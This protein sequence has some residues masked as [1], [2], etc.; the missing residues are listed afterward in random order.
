MSYVEEVLREL[1]TGVEAAQLATKANH[2]VAKVR[3]RE[4]SEGGREG[5]R[6]GTGDGR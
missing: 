6:E 4:G 2:K 3:G 1:E 5:G